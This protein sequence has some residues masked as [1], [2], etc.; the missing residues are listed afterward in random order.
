MLI[1][2]ERLVLHFVLLPH[3]REII[4]SLVS[5]DRIIR[6]SVC[7]LWL[8]CL[9]SRVVLVLTPTYSAP[10][11][12]QA[13]LIGLLLTCM[14][15]GR[16]CD[17]SQTKLVLNHTESSAT[18]EVVDAVSALALEQVVVLLDLLSSG[19]RKDTNV[20]CQVIPLILEDFLPSRQVD[21][22]ADCSFIGTLLRNSKLLSLLET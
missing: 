1:R 20:L 7:C 4:E 16:D 5:C 3:Q 18:A 21:A 17:L 10:A 6:F 8:P 14:Y 13:A 15:T 12:H 11:S 2:I 19:F 9:C 22:H